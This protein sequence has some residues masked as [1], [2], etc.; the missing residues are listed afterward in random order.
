L[1]AA[2]P[3]GH[4]DVHQDDVRAEALRLLDGLDAVAGLADDLD[5]GLDLDDEPE[6]LAHEGLV[7]CEQDADH[8]STSSGSRARTTKPP[9]SCGRAS[10]HTTL[11]H[12]GR[13]PGSSDRQRFSGA[14]R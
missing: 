10:N 13:S 3:D 12:T 1:V 9:P 14:S 7:V 11:D 2:M 5:V 4:A 8:C 6:P